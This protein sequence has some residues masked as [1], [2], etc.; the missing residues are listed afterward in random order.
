MWRRPSAGGPVLGGPQGAGVRALFG[1]EGGQAAQGGGD[2]EAAAR[3]AG[4][5]GG[6]AGVVAGDRGGLRG[7]I[8]VP[9]GA[10]QITAMP[11]CGA[12]TG[13]DRPP[14][15][16]RAAQG[17][18]GVA[19]GVRAARRPAGGIGVV[20]GTVQRPPDPGRRER[21]DRSGPGR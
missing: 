17:V 21:G 2:V 7:G 14:Q 8:V 10:G 13:Q 5:G 18:G 4:R 19:A 1:F 6:L 20:G 12:V 15:R 9:V 11:G 3:V 16:D